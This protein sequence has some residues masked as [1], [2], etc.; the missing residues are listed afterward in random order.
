MSF[1]FT[2]MTEDQAM[3]M[4]YPKQLEAY[5]ACRFGSGDVLVTASGGFGKSFIID[6]LRHFAASEVVTTATSGVAA[7]NINGA[8]THS[9]MSLP[10]G[11]P[12][13]QDLKKVGKKYRS[14]FKRNHPVTGIIIDEVS[15]VG[16]ETF[17]SILRRRERIS[18]TARCKFVRL[19]MFGDFFQIPNVVGKDTNILMDNYNTTKL[20]D[21]KLFLECVD[22]GLQI[23]ELD[24]NKRSGSDKLFTEMLENLRQGKNLEDTLNYFN[25]RVSDDR[26]DDAIYLTTTNDLADKINTKVLNDN[27]NQEWYYHAVVKGD[28]KEKDSKVPSLITLKEGLRVMAVYNDESD[29][30]VNGSTGTIIGMGT[31]MVEVAFDSGEI[32]WVGYFNQDKKEYYTND[33]DELCYKITASFSQLGIR[34]CSAISIH[35]SQSLSLNKVVMDISTGAFEYGQV[36]VGCSRLRSIDG[37]YLTTPIT[38]SDVKVC[39]VAKQFY[40]WL[41]GEDYNPSEDL[42]GVPS[43]Y[44]KYKIRLIVAGGR[45]FND[46]GYLVKSLDHMLKRY[47]REDVLIIEGGATGADRLGRE[48]AKL[49]GIDFTTQNADWKDLKTP[50]VLIKRNSYGEYNALAG[51][52]RNH[53]MGDMASHAVIYWD[54]KSTGSKDMLNYMKQLKKP[55]KVFSY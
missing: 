2:N 6:A 28:F 16:P 11:I 9:T 21:S 10:L 4:M 54:G 36:Y 53:K 22:N 23:F 17:D 19:L 52:A 38:T 49:R 1:D 29:L 27:P 15:M 14:L 44:H 24:Q 26:P 47:N 5:K 13:Q 12:T 3:D 42:S 41:R 39:P 32:A 45:D 46:F 48:Y 37:L 51:I 7:T 40:A 50:P 30:F 8:T 33:S 43:K 35:K 55:V 18:K 20:L 25:Q 34:P 31:D